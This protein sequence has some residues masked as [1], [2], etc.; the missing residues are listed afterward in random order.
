MVS[1]DLTRVMLLRRQMRE[2]LMTD[3]VDKSLESGAFE[4]FVDDVASCLLKKTPRECVFKSLA[5]LAGEKLTKEVLDD[6]CWRLAGNLQRLKTRAVVPWHKQRHKEWV[7]VQFVNAAKKRGGRKK[8]GWMFTFQ[9]LAGTPCPL[10]IQQFWTDRFCG[11][12]SHSLGFQWMPSHK[13]GQQPRGVYQHP[14][15]YVTLRMAVHIEPELCTGAGPDFKKI[16]LPDSLHRWNREQLKYR[17]RLEE[18]YECPNKYPDSLPCYRCPIGYVECRAGTHRS[19]FTYRYCPDCKGDDA[20]FD[21]DS[22]DVKC[23]SCFE[24]EVMRR[25]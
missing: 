13:S 11:R 4:S 6:T 3:Y 14:T 21:P 15:E 16:E 8:T 17:D 25:T 23:L 7:P 1:Y 18:G 12:M 19:T 24:R 2:S 5:H 9:V 10:T 22:S 20:A